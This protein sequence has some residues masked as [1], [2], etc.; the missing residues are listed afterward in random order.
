MKI[1]K[2]LLTGLFWLVI[3]ALLLAPVGL[4]FQISEAEMREYATPEAPVLKETAIGAVRQAT[5]TDLKEYVI[6]H[7]S[8][9]ST[10]YA[11]MDLEYDD[12]KNVRWFVGTGDEVQEGQVMGTG[13]NGDVV[14]TLTGI[15]T[16]MRVSSPSDCYI[17]FRLFTPPELSCRVDNRT[18]SILKRAPALTTEDGNQATLTFA[19]MQK[20]ADGSTNIRLSIDNGGYVYGEQLSELKLMTGRTY[21]ST[22]VLPESCVYQKGGAGQ[23]YARQ[24]TETGEYMQEVPVELGYSNGSIVAVSGVN[25]GDY[26]DSG[27]KAIM[28]G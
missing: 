13:A 14:S 1:W 15:V 16:E 12:L 4:I 7:G 24:V 21:N 23:W 18:L 3:I 25:E 26:F 17:R 20:N 9:T 27:Y 19:S 11:Y 22:L 2:K 8:F 5:R 6:V 10:T 28:G